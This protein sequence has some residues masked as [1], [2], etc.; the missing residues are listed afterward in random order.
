[1]SLPA[2]Y[3]VQGHFVPPQDEA[4][5]RALFKAAVTNVIV[6]I[7]SHCNRECQYCPVSQVDRLTVNHVLPQEQ[8][9]RILADLAAIGYSES[10][11]LNLYNE[12]TSDRPLLIA[13]IKAIRA[14]LPKA[15]I[16][17]STN[18][19]YLDREYFAEMVE[20]G[21]SELYITL[22]MPKGKPWHDGY[23]IGRMT[24]MS[25]RLGKGFRITSFA[26]GQTVQ[27]TARV[28]GIEVHAF[29]TNYDVFGSDRAGTIEKIR[30][31]APVRT[32][33]CDR[34][35]HDFTVSYDG[36]LFPC[37]QMFVDN[38][39]HRNKLAV[40]NLAGFANIF[41]AYASGA[42]AGWRKSLLRF[43]PKGSPCDTCTEASA[44]GTP[45][46]HAARDAVYRRFVGEP[47][48]EAVASDDAPKP[49]AQSPRKR[50]IRIFARNGD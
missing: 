33:P 1:M 6:E 16:Y 49:Q 21:L 10:V 43:G 7:S 31:S 17:F 14:A 48:A 46:D 9:D 35:F 32:A 25:A 39:E 26:P 37:C 44:P 8:F 27:G 3:F 50:W 28:L 30:N 42:M 36:T 41:D 15:R 38:E 47:E 18:G 5:K 24:E 34:P 13:R 2:Q 19:D 23:A 29:S 40:G 12:P 11:C 4:G 22:H 45:E 20:A